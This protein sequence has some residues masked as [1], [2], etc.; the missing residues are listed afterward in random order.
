M[1]DLSFLGAAQ[2]VTG[3]K[4]LLSTG[5]GQLL[6]DC[7]LFQGLKELR[8]R[9][10][11]PFPARPEDLDAILLTHAHIDHTGYLP[12]VVRAGYS[13]SVYA[14][15]GT[16]D[17]SR[18]LLPDAARLQEEDAQYAEKVGFSKHRPVLPLFTE[19]DAQAALRLMRP[20]RYGEEVELFPGAR[21]EFVEA[22]HILGSSFVLITLPSGQKRTRILFSGDLGRYGEPILRDPEP[23][24]P[25]DYLLVESTYGNR[26]HSDE[27]PKI[28]LQEVIQSTIRRGGQVIIPAFAVGR[29]Q[30][31]LYLLR[32]LENEGKIPKLPV[33]LDSPM[34]I[35]ATRQYLAHTEDHDLEMSKLMDEAINPLRTSRLEICRSISSSKAL[36]DR[37]DPLIIISASGMATGGRVLHHLKRRL[38]DE[39]ST[40]LFV[41]YQAVGTRGRRILDGEPEIVIHGQ[42]VPVRAKVERID[43]LSAHADANE[44]MRWLKTAQQA[45]RKCF[46]IHGEPEASQTLCRKIASEL[47]WEVVVP[48]LD[49]RV[50]LEG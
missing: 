8:L 19:K 21:A 13:G 17:L 1:I 12:R 37:N 33:Y 3:S 43:G 18:I 25:C 39:R 40:V 38:P 36:N 35:D 32:E 11:E 5:N 45:P 14:T 49:Q 15:K 16:V 4:F 47:S 50:K 48:A 41:G 29:T 42:T 7:G 27:D 6:V 20:L 31:L 34:A 9:N 2:T 28:K 46:V 26:L 22:G 30:L 23:C 24:P 10:W 44:I